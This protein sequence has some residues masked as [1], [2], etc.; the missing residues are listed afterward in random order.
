MD[1]IDKSNCMYQSRIYTLIKN[2]LKLWMQVYKK[3]KITMKNQSE[4][5]KLIF[6]IKKC[7]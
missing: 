4:E 1:Y 5:I 6:F 7:I 2:N 3:M